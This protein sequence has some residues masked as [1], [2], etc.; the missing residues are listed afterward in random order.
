[1]S[2]VSWRGAPAS[3]SHLARVRC[4]SGS[5]SIF[6][7][8]GAYLGEVGLVQLPWMGWSNAAAIQHHKPATLVSSVRRRRLER[9]VCTCVYMCVCVCVCVYVCVCVCVCV[10]VSGLCARVC[11]VT[12]SP[13]GSRAVWLSR[14][15][16]PKSIRSC[17]CPLCVRAPE[18]KEQPNCS[19]KR[20]PEPGPPANLPPHYPHTPAALLRTP[21]THMRPRRD[22]GSSCRVTQPASQLFQTPGCR[23]KCS[24]ARE[25]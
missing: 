4:P 23:K 25:F 15:L 5:T 20:V 10:C 6:N 16:L 19:S 13:L 24:K 8:A 12:V 14:L 18:A 2:P 21:H 22:E 3:R 1:M 11:E 9:C 7:R 17:L